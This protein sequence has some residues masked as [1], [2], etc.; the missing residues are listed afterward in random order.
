MKYSIIFSSFIF[1]VLLLTA[2]VDV[3][4]VELEDAE[5]RLVIEAQ[6]YDR[7]RPAS[8]MLTRSAEFFGNPEFDF[9]SGAQV[10]ITDSAGNIIN[11]SE[12]SAGFYSSDFLG[13][14]GQTYNI[15][16]ISEDKEYTAQSELREALLIDSLTLVNLREEFNYD[17][18]EYGIYCH[19][20]DSVG[21]E[22]YAKLNIYKNWEPSFGLYLYDDF[23]TDGLGFDFFFW[24]DFMLEGDTVG[25]ELLTMDPQVYEYFLTL[26][27][28]AGGGG[29]GTATPYNP[30]SNLSG[31]ALG[32]FGAFGYSAALIIVEEGAV[33]IQGKSF[34]EMKGLL[35]QR[36]K[37]YN[38]EAAN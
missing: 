14:P 32:Y 4:D 23:Y 1:S 29:T 26:T 2:C 19:F 33:S 11:L 27:E 28:V 15:K 18:D 8:V 25:V 5:P 9:V 6:I 16:V 31:E 34:S 37:N 38:E 3:I 17:S 35:E 36:R 20:S 24:A 12:D 22:D 21:R 30:T 13:T 7:L 10:T